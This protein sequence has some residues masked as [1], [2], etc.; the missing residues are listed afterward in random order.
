MAISDQ[1]VDPWLGH[2]AQ[3]K[4]EGT[5]VPYDWQEV[6]LGYTITREATGLLTL[7]RAPLAMPHV[8]IPVVAAAAAIIANPVVTRRFWQG[9]R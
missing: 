3:L 5:S 7:T 4:V 6:A 8:W 2:L 9:W 1:F